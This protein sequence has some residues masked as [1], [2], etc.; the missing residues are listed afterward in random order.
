MSEKKSDLVKVEV[1][2]RIGV[3]DENAPGGS[4]MVEPG[5][6]KEPVFAELPKDAANNL[7]DAGAVKIKA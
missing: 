2:R 6:K 4:R 5:T 7:V 1:V 3:P